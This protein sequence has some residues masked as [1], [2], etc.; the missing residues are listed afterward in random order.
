M[1]AKKLFFITLAFF[2]LAGS[3]LV[4]YNFVLPQNG[5]GN[6][7]NSNQDRPL[8][9]K[10]KKVSDKKAFSLAI[11]H[12][13]QS[14]KYYL[15]DNGQLV[16]SGFNGSNQ[17]I[18][19]DIELP[20]LYRA[21]WSPDR[22]KVLSYFKKPE[23][24]Q[25]YSYDYETKNSVLLNESVKQTAWSPSGEKIVY[26]YVK[27]E[28]NQNSIAVANADTS[29]WKI[30]LQ[31]RLNNLIV[32]WPLPDKIYLHEAPARGVKASLFSLDYPSGNLKKI[33]ADEFG[34]AAKI[35]LDGQKIL[36][37]TTDENGKNLKL[38]VISSDGSK[39]EIS[40]AT[41]VEKCLWSS[42]SQNIF[43]AAPQKLSEFA[44]WP[45]DYLAGR[46][47]VQDDFYLIDALTGK[48]T[49]IAE[50][51]DRQSF[52]AAE[53]TLSPQEDFLFFIDRQTGFIYSLALKM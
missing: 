19:S 1:N 37:Q 52:D 53:L 31:T 50:S 10:I 25:R 11:D 42:D 27:Q 7:D 18:I 16:K 6:K 35:S 47:S 17:T 2:I 9:M 20:E 49:K 4:I 29:N 23:G 40:T 24:T 34:L 26:Q 33:I 30:I 45:D 46:V 43:C 12:D 28:D 48:K 41:L 32:S 22:K 13:R 38:L 39:K 14:I 5:S 21:I 3:S 44:V 36:Y 15:K 51:N 8:N